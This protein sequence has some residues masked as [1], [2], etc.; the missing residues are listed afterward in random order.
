MIN[1]FH[2]IPYGKST[3]SKHRIGTRFDTLE[4]MVGETFVILRVYVHPLI[5]LR[6]F[7]SIQKFSLILMNMQMRSFSYR[8]TGWKDLPNCITEDIKTG[9]NGVLMMF[10]CWNMF[11][12]VA[13][14]ILLHFC[15]FSLIF[16]NM[17]IR[18][19][20]NLTTGRKTCVL[21]LIWHKF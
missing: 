14:M 13:F 7:L 12:Y 3:M 19:F 9:N 1:I 10:L 18:W 17:Q 21:A 5:F 2:I 11:I 8:T 4:H 15:R 16:I 6:F 20:T